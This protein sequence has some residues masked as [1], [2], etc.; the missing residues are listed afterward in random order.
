VAWN[1]RGTWRRHA[2]LQSVIMV[3]LG[4]VSSWYL[5]DD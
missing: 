1:E 3:A 2:M 5:P 4:P